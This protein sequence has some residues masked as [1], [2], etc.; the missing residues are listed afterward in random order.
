M[1][2]VSTSQLQLNRLKQLRNFQRVTQ[3]RSKWSQLE[4]VPGVPLHLYTTSTTHR[5]RMQQ[6]KT[7]RIAAAE[8]SVRAAG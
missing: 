2:P 6:Q 5:A 3:N 4:V 8:L 1:E 7:S